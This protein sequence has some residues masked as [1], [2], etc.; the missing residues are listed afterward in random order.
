MNDLIIKYM[1]NNNAIL[2]EVV[3]SIE[4]LRKLAESDNKKIKE[5]RKEIDLLKK[6]LK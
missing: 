4:L 1:G 2:N 6:K 3:E 5:L